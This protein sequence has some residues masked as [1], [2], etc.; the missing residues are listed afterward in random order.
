[1]NIV[2][3]SPEESAH[4]ELWEGLC[5]ITNFLNGTRTIRG[6]DGKFV[7]EDISGHGQHG[8]LVGFEKCTSH[9][10]RPI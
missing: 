6:P 7:V 10:S 9:H 5:S 1:M 8:H 4:P 3:K 2:A